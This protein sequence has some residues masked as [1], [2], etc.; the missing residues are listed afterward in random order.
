VDDTGDISDSYQ[1]GPLQNGHEIPAV[2]RVVEAVSPRP[3]SALDQICARGRWSG[4]PGRGLGGA[5]TACMRGA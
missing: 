1:G 5:A 4:R 2:A 3:E